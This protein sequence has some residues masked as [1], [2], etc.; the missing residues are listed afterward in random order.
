M[1]DEQLDCALD[2]FR[3]LPPQRVSQHLEGALDLVPELCED[4]L[5]SVDQ[6]LLVRRDEVAGKDFLICDYNR[7]GDSYRSPWS[8]QY[9][10]ELDDG[11]LPS[12]GVRRMEIEANDAFDQYRELYY[13]GGLTSVYLWDADG[14]FAGCVLVKKTGDSS[15][16]I[17]GTWDAIHVIEV[18]DL[19]KRRA[20]YK[21]TSTIIL[22]LQTERPASGNM[23]LGGNLTRQITQEHDVSDDSPHV[24][25]IG[26]M[27]EEQESKIRQSLNDVYFGKTRD[28]MN[29]LR[30]VAP[31]PD[32]N[33]EEALRSE[34]ASALRRRQNDK[35]DTEA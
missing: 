15:K 33:Q 21:L 25:N 9:F 32:Q 11:A 12:D 14:G 31:L 17:Q 16:T 30:S 34:L 28:V 23:S 10:P 8:N 24:A 35:N 18:Q 6:P 13:E 4:L 7:D 19:H 26:R 3:R 20:Q 2:L 22:S 5:T 1:T 27:I 29:G